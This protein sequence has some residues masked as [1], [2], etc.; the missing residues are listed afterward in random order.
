MTLPD[1]VFPKA[2]GGVMAEIGKE[3]SC[4]RGSGAEVVH[5][6]A[7]GADRRDEIQEIPMTDTDLIRRLPAQPST[8]DLN[9]WLVS[10]LKGEGSELTFGQIASIAKDLSA[11]LRSPGGDGELVARFHL[12]VGDTAF[13]FTTE[14][15]LK[16]ARA[17]LSQA[18]ATSAPAPVSGERDW[19]ALETAAW[20]LDQANKPALAT[21][22][23]DAATALRTPHGLPV[24]TLADIEQWR[25][26]WNALD[27]FAAGPLSSYI[28]TK[29]I[30]RLSPAS[31][32]DGK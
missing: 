12:L 21:L 30:S 22:V 29:T 23:R 20:H 10:R 9:L 2:S 1:P 27:G 8:T 3:A 4:E 11:A 25:G 16:A 32:E 7:K 5:T 15:D 28:G 14:A 13:E 26:E 19:R 6:S 17:A 31:R 24:V 18:E